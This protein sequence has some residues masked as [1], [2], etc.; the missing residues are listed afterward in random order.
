[1]VSAR[2]GVR[3]SASISPYVSKCT[4]LSRRAT[5]LTAPGNF[6]SSMYRCTRRGTLRSRS[7]DMP[8]SSGAAST[9][10]ARSSVRAM[11]LRLLQPGV[12]VVE[13]VVG[14][15]FD[16]LDVRARHQGRRRSGQPHDERLVQHDVVQF[17]VHLLAF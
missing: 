10:R 16:A 15:G 12:V 8:T 2:M 6:S 11:P 7:D 13:P 17:A 9:M 5:R 4:T 1:M 3:R 14:A